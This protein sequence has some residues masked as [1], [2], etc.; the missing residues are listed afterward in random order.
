MNSLRK[1]LRSGAA[2]NDQ[3]RKKKLEI[4]V[5]KVTFKVKAQSGMLKK[6]HQK[7]IMYERLVTAVKRKAKGLY[8][9]KHI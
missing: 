4:F 8:N 3:V 7:I 1:Y 5:R 9:L 2:R 6:L